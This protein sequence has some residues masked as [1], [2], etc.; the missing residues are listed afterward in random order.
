LENKFFAKIAKQILH[1]LISYFLLRLDFFHDNL[2]IFLSASAL[3]NCFG[4]KKL[5][6]LEMQ[7]FVTLKL[8]SQPKA[9]PV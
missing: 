2:Q 8:S 4:K 3:L 5:A 1:Y 6:E 9:A 7:N